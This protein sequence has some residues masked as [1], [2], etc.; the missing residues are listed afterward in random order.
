APGEVLVEYVLAEP[1]SYALTVTRTAAKLV[2]LAAKPT[3]QAAAARFTAA[4]KDGKADFTASRAELFD[5]I[6]R[7]ATV[8][9]ARRVFVVP[10]GALHLVAFDSLLDTS[11]TAPP[12][13]TTVPSASV[14]V[15]LRARPQNTQPVRPLLAV[16]GVP[17]DRMFA[18]PAALTAARR[19]VDEAGLF[20]ASY[21]SKVPVLASSEREVLT[22]A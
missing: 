18:S 12:I 10:D 7:P 2:T 13:L 4:L 5:L 8:S 6:I 21:P 1:Q 22:A 11:N 17:Y 15:L 19:S 20:D 9:S 16:G 14:F 3:I